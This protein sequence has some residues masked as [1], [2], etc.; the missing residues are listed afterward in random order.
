MFQKSL[1]KYVSPSP[2][3]MVSPIILKLSD[4]IERSYGFDRINQ[5]YYGYIDRLQ[6][7][8]PQYE[9]CGYFR[10]GMQCGLYGDC[11]EHPEDEPS[12][13]ACGRGDGHQRAFYLYGGDEVNHSHDDD[14][15][16]SANGV[17]SI[18]SIT[19]ICVSS[20]SCYTIDSAEQSHSLARTKFDI[21]ID[22]TSNKPGEQS[23]EKMIAGL[24][25]GEVFR[26]VL[27][28]L[29]DSGDLFLGQN[30]YKLEKA[31][32]VDTAFLSLIER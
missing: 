8:R 11:W 6:L 13:N 14:F 25:L 3:A 1:E 28:E 19:S 20:V 10:Y 7:C 23:F 26:L 29:I 24:Y 5:R 18:P 2:P 17:L 12:G 30:S 4:L 16:Y 27:T 21:I 31:Y 15:G 22:E 9:D 32:A